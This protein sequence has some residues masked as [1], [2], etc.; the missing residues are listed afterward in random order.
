MTPGEFFAIARG[1]TADAK[2]IREE[3]DAMNANLIAH[4]RACAGDK[5]ADPEKFMIYKARKAKDAKSEAELERKLMRIG[6]GRS[7]E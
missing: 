6:G 2:R 7:D 3:R 5:E 4:I 1:K